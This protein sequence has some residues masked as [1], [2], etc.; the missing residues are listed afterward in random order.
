[1]WLALSEEAL[2]SP[3]DGTLRS[4]LGRG[5]YPDQLWPQSKSFLG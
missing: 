3:L 4:G 5:L 2:G 1:M